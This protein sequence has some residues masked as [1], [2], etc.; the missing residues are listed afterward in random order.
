[1]ARNRYKNFTEEAQKV[2]ANAR[3]EAIRLRHRSVGTAHLLLGLL[4]KQDPLIEALFAS[5]HT[6]SYRVAQTLE[7]VLGVGNKPLLS[8]PAIN[9]SARATLQRAEEEAAADQAELVSVQHILLAILTETDSATQGVLESLDIKADVI[10]QMLSSLT[11]KGY[12]NLQTAIH[13]Q[14][15]YDQTPTINQFSR[16]LTLAALSNELDPLIGREAELERSMQ[17]LSRRSKNN[18]VLIGPAGVGKT[19]IAEG[20]AMRII[21]NRVP[22]NLRGLRVVALDIPAL[23]INTHLRG[24]YEER[25]K[26]ILQESSEAGNI[27]FVLDE[28]HTLMRSGSSQGS[29]DAA[30]LFKPMLARGTFRCIG[31][32]TLDEYRTSI[33]TDPA[34]ERRFQ[35]VM[36]G[37]T[38]HEDTVEIL[39]GLRPH[40]ETFHQVTITDEAIDAASRLSARYI[41]ERFLPDKAI[42]LLDEAAARLSVQ[43]TSAPNQI[44]QLRDKAESLRREKEYAIVHKNFPQALSLLKQER[45]AREQLQHAEAAW[46]E[47]NQQAPVIGKQDI[48][49]V[50]SAM[51]G[52]P[53]SH[54]SSEEGER[55]LQLEEKLHQ[56]V[57]GQ[58][59]AVETVAR[60]IR[61]ARTDIRNRRRPIGTFLFVGPTGVGKTE[62]A[63]A[64]A[65]TL[66]GDESALLQFDM[67]EFMEHHNVS[68]LVGAPPGYVGYTEAGQ[69]IEAVRRKPY[70]VVLFDEIEKAHPKVFDLLLQV[71]EDGRLTSGD[72]QTVNFANTIII[73]TSNTGTDR[74]KKSSAAFFGRKQEGAQQ[75]DMSA[76]VN[77]ALKETF[78]PEFLNRLDDIIVFHPLTQ[79]QIREIVNNQIQKIATRIAEQG[80]KLQVTDEVRERLAKQGYSAEYGAR[81]LRRVV[82]N[83]LTDMLA[84]ALLQGKIAAGQEVVVEAGEKALTLRQPVPVGSSKN[85]HA[86]A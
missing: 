74:L 9:P 5:I 17:I 11:A 67:S 19:A 68:R 76:Q 86:A 70:S 58:H 15:L 3:Q 28:L 61:R 64:I 32:T 78:R 7:Y 31:S 51:T 60:A 50:V 41:H 54:I 34:L 16:D 35:P 12:D 39:R 79:G 63:R 62:L 45:Q 65:E 23:T 84:E 37:E 77:E 53:L 8:T 36:V 21:E 6:S 49:Q 75:R 72:G 27:I 85:Q 10:R 18:P 69:L 56:R 46:H 38:S 59:E 82:E 2:I 71:L 80:I 26:T 48:A 29:T 73:L 24:E 81:Q 40:Y 33:E 20:L 55:L 83:Q 52:I 14:G 43:R 13:Y 66:F 47:N 1:M 42:D 44:L 57:I 30:N 4:K 22:E 25:L